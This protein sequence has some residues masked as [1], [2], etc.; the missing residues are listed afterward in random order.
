ME[1]DIFPILGIFG[2][3]IFNKVARADIGSENLDVKQLAFCLGC[4]LYSKDY[5]EN[6]AFQLKNSIMEVRFY[7]IR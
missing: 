6:R 7:S 5:E 4:H 3:Q 2:L 1:E